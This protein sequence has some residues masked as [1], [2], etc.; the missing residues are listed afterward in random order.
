MKPYCYF[1]SRK[2]GRCEARLADL[3][4]TFVYGRNPKGLKSNCILP[5]LLILSLLA[6]SWPAYRDLISSISLPSLL[7]GLKDLGRIKML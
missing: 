4:I 1:N 7:D 2:V 6:D 5:T 3:H